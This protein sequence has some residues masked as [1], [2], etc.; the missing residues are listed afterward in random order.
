MLFRSDPDQASRIDVDGARVPVTPAG[1]Q[2][3]A[4]PEATPA[5]RIEPV[6]PGDVPRYDD[7]AT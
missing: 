1:P 4:T 6:R 3:S 2:A 7:E 5:P